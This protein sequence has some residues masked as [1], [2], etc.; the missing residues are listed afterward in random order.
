M[1]KRQITLFT[2]FVLCLLAMVACGGDNNAAPTQAPQAPQA[3]SEPAQLGQ[4]AAT[5]AAPAATEAA[6]EAPAAS[7]AINSLQDVENAVI[8]IIAQGTFVDPE[9]GAQYNVAG[10]GS[11]FIIDESGI[12]VTNN[13]V[14]TGAASLQ[15]YVA[16]EDRPRNAR[17]LGVSECS[18][19]A[20]IDIDGEGFP[21]LAWHDGPV[22]VGLDVYAAGFPLGD[23][24]FTLTRGIVAK[25]NANG[26]TN[27]AS[28]DRVIQHDATINPGN[29]G[30]PLVDSNGQV[31]G[32]NYAGAAGVDQYFAI[33][34]EEALPIIDQL[35]GGQDVTS[36]GINGL[37]VTDGE[38]ISGIWVSSV[39]SGS[40]ADEAR[41]EAGDILVSLE[42]LVLAT[43]GTMADYC[44]VLRSRGA[45]DTMD[46][47]VLRFS[48]GEVL[49]GQLNGRELETTVVFSSALED[50]VAAEPAGSTAPANEYMTITDDTG[51]L[52][53]EVPTTWTETAGGPWT[54]QDGS[55]IGLS[56]SASPNLQDYLF[57]WG[58]PGMFF[59]ATTEL[60][61]TID[62]TLDLVS[63]NSA[64][65]AAD[66]S[67]DGRYD[68]ADPLY[69]GK[70]DLWVNCGG[71]G[72]VYVVLVVWPEDA[73]YTIVVTVQA[74]TQADLEAL[75]HILNTFIV[76]L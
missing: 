19:L 56:V 48:T 30:G 74:V 9:L 24:E 21:Y 44:D 34:R 17:V 42:D 29:S 57:S 5:E 1:Q 4:P 36:I 54:S 67:Y 28:V 59:G 8:Q 72:T 40:P 41:I 60:D 61:G 53:V 58:T 37:A 38:S 7:G 63:S 35:R 62:D 45:A 69:S 47:Q 65:V 3:T 52:I 23:P 43:D 27:W 68:Y 2:I 71:Q 14:V 25:E 73:S 50:Q 55:E 26:E 49:E 76:N 12:A 33:A 16:G 70:Y 15:V 18:D 13:H 11:G 20:V 75:D 39:K 6:P 64:G 31:V 66:C 22:S 32:V 10:S 46:V 51:T